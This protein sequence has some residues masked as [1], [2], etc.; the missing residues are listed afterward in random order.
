MSIILAV[1]NNATPHLLHV[2]KP[3]HSNQLANV[4]RKLC[5]MLKDVFKTTKQ[6]ITFDSENKLSLMN[7]KFS[8]DVPMGN[9]RKTVLDFETSEAIDLTIIGTHG[10]RGLKE[11]VIG[12]KAMEILHY[13]SQTLMT[14]P[15]DYKTNTIE[16]VLYPIRNAKGASQKIDY[17]NPFFTNKLQQTHLLGIY[18]AHHD[19]EIYDVTNTLKDI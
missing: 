16:R 5:G 12:T 19:D 8:C 10:I 18:H 1:A 9:I 11:L 15:T 7:L 2:V 14:I 4:S 3:M 17:I 6:S 13:S